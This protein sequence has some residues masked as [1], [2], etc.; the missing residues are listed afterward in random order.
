MTVQNDNTIQNEQ[1]SP[2]ELNFRQQ[3][4]AIKN[5]YE[6]QLT[7][8]RE[9]K[10]ALLRRLEEQQPQEDDEPYIDQ[11]KLKKELHNFG[12]QTQKQTQTEI[13]NAV[14]TALREERKQNYIK[15]NSDF[16]EV[17]KHAD[18]LAQRDPDLAESILEMPESFERQKLVYKNI[19]AMGLHQPEVPKQTIQD[20]VD[21]NRRTP[22][23]QPS[24]TGS[25]PYTTQGDFSPAG[26]KAAY[27]KLQ[28]LKANLRI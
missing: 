1:L 25:A 21:Q 23:Y 16:Y 15:Q 8:E 12:Q 17:L 6:S 2:K 28:E 19:K 3:E 13:Q 20:K 22:Y 27:E 11:K 18:K 5:H 7:R 4:Q 26:Q 10:Q 14:Q 24:G 9:E